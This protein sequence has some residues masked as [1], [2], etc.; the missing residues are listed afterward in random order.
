MFEGQCAGMVLQSATSVELGDG[1]PCSSK[2]ARDIGLL[3]TMEVPKADNTEIQASLPEMWR[4][5]QPNGSAS[6][7]MHIEL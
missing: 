2:D 7:P 4:H 3:E 5:Q 6:T 1:E